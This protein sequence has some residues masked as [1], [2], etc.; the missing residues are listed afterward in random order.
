MQK[1][2]VIIVI[3]RK[4]YLAPPKKIHFVKRSLQMPTYRVSIFFTLDWDGKQDHRR[5]AKPYILH[6]AKLQPSFQ[7]YLSM[8]KTK[9]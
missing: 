8:S 3:Y 5:F 2:H 1:N 6:F 4:K 7:I 9:L